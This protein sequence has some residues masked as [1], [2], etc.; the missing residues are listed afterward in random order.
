MTRPPVETIAL[1]LTARA[2]A[3]PGDFLLQFGSLVGAHQYLRLYRLFRSY[4][5]EGARVLDWGA[6][7]GHFSYFL[8]RSGYRASG[9]SLLDGS[10]LRWLPDREYS[11]LRGVEREPV[12]LP[13]ADGSFDAVASVGVLEHVRE[14]GGNE[15]GSLAEIAR[16]LRPG[17]VL[18]CYHFPNRS[19]WIDWAAR[20]VPGKHHHEFRFTRADI[21]SLTAGAG[22]RLLEAGRYGFLPRNFGHRLPG[23]LRRSRPL[24]VAWDAL[25]SLLAVPFSTVCQNYYFVALKLDP[26][27]S[28]GGRIERNAEKSSTS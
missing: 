8:Q 7:N 21:E 28:S 18:A 3:H 1:E 11:F 2:N 5:P 10:F 26:A 24:A 23:G 12:L 22:L 27:T 4:V 17:G 6:G 15:A 25:D 14:T 9:Y 13:Y 19:S 16:V 20:R